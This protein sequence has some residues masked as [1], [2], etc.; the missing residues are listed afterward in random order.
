MR[1]CAGRRRSSAIRTRRLN[2]WR[3]FEGGQPEVGPHS[4]DGHPRS[5]KYKWA[6]EKRFP[7]SW[8]IL[9]TRLH[10]RTALHTPHRGN[11]ALAH[12]PATF[13]GVTQKEVGQL[14]APQALPRETFGRIVLSN[15]HRISFD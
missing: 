13:L 14:E 7:I 3:A 8:Q 9:P 6:R 5:A 15:V 4:P 1:R 12:Y 10:R 11:P 2:N